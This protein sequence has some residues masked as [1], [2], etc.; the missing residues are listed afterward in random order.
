[1]PRPPRPALAGRLARSRTHAAAQAALLLAGA[2][3]TP[4]SPRAPHR[5]LPSQA[6][7]QLANVAVKRW[8]A[9]MLA[10]IGPPP[11]EGIAVPA[12]HRLRSNEQ[13]RPSLLWQEPC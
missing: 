2:P 6:E 13:R 10:R 5:V 9:R 4:C 12:A 11:G 7:D 1:M 8:S 3:A